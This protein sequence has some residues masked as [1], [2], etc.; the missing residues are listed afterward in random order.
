VQTQCREHLTKMLVHDWYDGPVGG[1]VTFDSIRWYSFYLLDWDSQHQV[2]IFALQLIFGEVDKL[3]HELSI[4]SPQWP[5]WF[6]AELVHPSN[7]AQEWVSSM[8]T[9]CHDIDRIK[10]VFVWDTS[11]K[12]VLAVL[13]LP[14]EFE[15]RGVSWFDA[16]E[17]DEGA[18]NWFE[19]LSISG[20]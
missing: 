1:I 17:S 9:Q 11:G 4:E 18:L 16:I 13:Q 19:I 5:V 6:P 15:S 20:K 8:K 10:E 3:I 7:Q 2:R 12:C 14:H